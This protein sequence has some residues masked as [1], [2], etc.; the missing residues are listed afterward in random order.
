FIA[1]GSIGMCIDEFNADNFDHGPPGFVGGGYMG[2]VQTNGRRIETTPRPPGARRGGRRW[3]EAVRSSY[4]SALKPG[5][6]VHGSMYSY[7]DVYLDLDPTYRDR[8]NRPL[9]RITMDFHD[10][11]LKQNAFL[12]DRFAEIFQA[13]GAREVI[14]EYRK[15]PYDIREYQ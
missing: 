5:T 8:F 7:R 3:K 1:S 12:T 14:K 9:L 15:G 2:Q 10:N 6:G 13:M 4:Q 11:E